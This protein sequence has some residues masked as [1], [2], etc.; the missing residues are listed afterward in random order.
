MLRAMP[1]LVADTPAER[2]PHATPSLDRRISALATAQHGV[3]HRRQLRT[4]GVSDSAIGR[5]AASGRLHRVH[6]SV[7][8]VGHTVLGA[9]G[10]WLAAVLACRPGAVLSHSSAGALWDIRSSAA[11]RIDVTVPGAG[12]PA[13]PRL[14]VHRAREL[15]AGDVTTHRAIP[16][17]SPARTILDLAAT[18]PERALEKVL[19]RAERAEVTDRRALLAIAAASN[20]HR[21]SARLLRVLSEHVPGTTVTRSELEERM[22]LLCR[23]HGLPRPLVNHHVEGIEVDFVFRGA[24]LLVEADSWRYHRDRDAFERDRER[25]A[26]FARAGYRVLRF[27]DRQMRADPQAVAATIAALM[28]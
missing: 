16:V 3:V 25:D 24:R 7:Y 18:L 14:R 4:L 27:T 10:R 15:R 21:G 6:R 17:T 28:R 9:H 2:A 20:G 23:A 8:A 22:L 5:R 26:I 1:P 13:V 12:R 11:G 19:D